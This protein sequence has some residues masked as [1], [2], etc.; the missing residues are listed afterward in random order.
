MEYDHPHILLQ[1]KKGYFRKMVAETGP[2]MAAMLHKLAKEVNATIFN[3]FK[4]SILIYVLIN[5]VY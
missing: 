4:I 3:G 5:Y 1:N 2:A